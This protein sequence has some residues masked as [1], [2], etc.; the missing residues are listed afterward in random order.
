MKTRADDTKTA[1]RNSHA[2]GLKSASLVRGNQPFQVQNRNVQTSTG[3]GQNLTLEPR[4]LQTNSV[5]RGA[6]KVLFVTAQGSIAK[7][8]SNPRLGFMRFGCMA[9]RFELGSVVSVFFV[10]IMCN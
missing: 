6:V 4:S 3:K 2:H 5:G 7:G 1:L 8:L 10:A 9:R